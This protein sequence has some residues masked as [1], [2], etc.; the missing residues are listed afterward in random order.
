MSISKVNLLINQIKDAIKFKY[1]ADSI[2]VKS[3]NT[4]VGSMHTHSIFFNL[5]NKRYKSLINLNTNEKIFLNFKIKELDPK[6]MNI[7]E[8]ETS[9]LKDLKIDLTNKDKVINEFIKASQKFDFIKKIKTLPN[10]SFIGNDGVGK[11]SFKIYNQEKI[12]YSNYDGIIK[13]KHIK[14]ELFIFYDKNSQKISE[15]VTLFIPVTTSKIEQITF[16]LGE[17]IDNIKVFNKIYDIQKEYLINKIKRKLNL[18]L[19]IETDEVI[20]SYLPLLEICNY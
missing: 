14:G 16:N 2:M 8:Q 12:Y 9:I 15:F 17:E 19:K 13:N 11:N 4:T 3:A 20:K 10:R 1:N 5:N 18:N 7:S 6:E